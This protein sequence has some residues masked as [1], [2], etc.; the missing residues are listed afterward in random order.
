MGCETISARLSENLL[1]K[2]RGARNQ[3][4]VITQDIR[5]I[6]KPT[7]FKTIDPTLVLL[8]SKGLKKQSKPK[9]TQWG[10]FLLQAH[11]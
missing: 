10:S 4:H 3:S 1:R 7:F 2:F 5:L 6:L 11:R 8:S 9:S